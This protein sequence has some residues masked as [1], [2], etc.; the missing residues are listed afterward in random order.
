M[1]TKKRPLVDIL[2]NILYIMAMAMD[3]IVRVMEILLRAQ[4]KTWHKERKMR[5]N[6]MIKSAENIKRLNDLIDQVDYGE[7]LKGREETYQY[8]QED[9]YKLC[10]FILL[11]CDRD[12]VSEENSNE[13]FKLMREQEG[14]GDITEDDLKWFYLQK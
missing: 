7:A 6:Q 9:A 5:F 14:T 1:E 8:Y 3:R 4:G 2:A 13:T 12:A 10:R 11:F